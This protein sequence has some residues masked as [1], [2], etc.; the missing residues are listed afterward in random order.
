MSDS[1]GK[2]LR[3]EIKELPPWEV[4][5][6]LPLSRSSQDCYQLPVCLML[7]T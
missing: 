4:Q 1:E 7:F 5:H 2:V 3:Q 6:L